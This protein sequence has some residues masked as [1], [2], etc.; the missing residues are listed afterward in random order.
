MKLTDI[1]YARAVMEKHGIAP[2]KRFGQNF[3][4]SENVVSRIA[5]TPGREDFDIGII[6]IGP[7]IGTLTQKLAERYKK[8]VSI[9]IDTTLLP[10]LE[11]TLSEYDNVKIISG[12]AMKTDFAELVRAEF[13]GMRVA[14]CANLPYYITSPVI[15]RLLETDGLFESVTVM[16]QKEVADRL[17]AAPA[18]AEYGTITASCAYWADIEKVFNVSPANFIPP[19]KV[20]SSVIRM[21]IYK[22]PPVACE[23]RENLFRVI[24]G[25]FAKRRKT[26]SNSLSGETN[27]HT[28]AEIEAVL[29]SLGYRA[30]VRGE[31]LG[32]SDFAKISDALDL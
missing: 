3:L 8:V 21:N 6:E 2:Q 19:P 31:T 24:R 27:Q 13:D 30:D 26:L 12:D 14:V 11:D 29:V 18:T 1:S 16:I 20:T 9:E 5:D 22:E 4:I 32:L 23:N 7:G 10:V 17:V 15:M 28:K 25:A